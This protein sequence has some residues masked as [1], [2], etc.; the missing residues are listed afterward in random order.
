MD[1]RLKIDMDNSAFEDNP[2][3]ELARILRDVASE[4][5]DYVDAPAAYVGCVR[6]INGNDV[7]E[8][9]IKK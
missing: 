9:K 3:A 5:R 8:W 2:G 6:D 1:F 7:G 4:C